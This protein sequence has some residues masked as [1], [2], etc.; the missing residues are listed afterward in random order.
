[1]RSTSPG[2]I[3]HSTTPQSTTPH[4]TRAAEV[5]PFRVLCVCEGN[6]CRSPVAAVLLQDALGPEVEVTSAGT[7]AVVG[8]PVAPEMEAL[9]RD[10]SLGSGG[11]TAR[12]L[13]ADQLR[14]ADLVLTMTTRQRGSAVA[15]A[16]AVVRRTFTLREL[17]RLLLGVETD[18]LGSAT[19]E[20]LRRAVPAAA[21]RRAYVADL[22]ADVAAFG[23][24]AGG[25]PGAARGGRA[26]RRRP[27]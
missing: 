4:S 12:Q 8:A 15:L 18:A 1:M 25:P 22:R 5:R 3:T 13:A 19:A 16:P 2:T 10:R 14:A 9:L 26:G 21:A 23:G 27:R 20:R 11:S 24:R 17:A 6:I 7:R